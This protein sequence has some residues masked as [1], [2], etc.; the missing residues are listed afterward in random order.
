MIPTTLPP[1]FLLGASGAG[2][3]EAGGKLVDLFNGNGIP[4][5]FHTSK[6]WL[7]LAVLDDARTGRRVGEVI[8]TPNLTLLNPDKADP[9]T[10]QARFKN[11]AALNRAH[12]SLIAHVAQRHRESGGS[13]VVIAELAN[14]PTIPY[15]H[16]EP[17]RQTGF[18][19]IQWIDQH[20]LLPRAHCWLITAPF[21]ERLERNDGRPGKLP[22]DELTRLYPDLDNDPTYDIALA[23]FGSRFHHIPNAMPSKELFLKLVEN[24]FYD[25]LVPRFGLEGI[26]RPLDG[27]DRDYYPIVGG[28]HES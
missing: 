22:P 6:H 18:Q 2:K 14:G 3:S 25:V 23:T 28:E 10:F 9:E 20:G 4:V 21:S 19:F 16:L 5:E 1:M 24:D 11:G 17:I 7:G 27:R 12:E 13:V 26:R 8:E 15:G